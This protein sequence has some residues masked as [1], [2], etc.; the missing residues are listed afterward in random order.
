MSEQI[1]KLKEEALKKKRKERS[2]VQVM[3]D[4]Q[5]IDE[6]YLKVS[7]PEKRPSILRIDDNSSLENRKNYLRYSAKDLSNK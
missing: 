7:A 1:A 2:F 5:T 6:E 3:K 4:Y